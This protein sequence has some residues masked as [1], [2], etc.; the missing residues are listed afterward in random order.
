[1]ASV[2]ELCN[3]IAL[4]NK[5]KNILSGEL[6]QI[7]QQYGDNIYEIGYRGDIEQLKQALTGEYEFKGQTVE[8]GIP[9]VRIKT[10]HKHGD[11]KLLSLLLPVVEIV[12]FNEVIPSMN[13]IFIKMVGGDDSISREQFTE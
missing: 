13:D 2:E 5:S 12:H 1:M 10:H 4:I 3:D 6:T 9:I 8:K 11:N 7:R